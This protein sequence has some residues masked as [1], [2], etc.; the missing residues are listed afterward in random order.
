MNSRNKWDGQSRGWRRESGGLSRSKQIAA[1]AAVDGEGS[2][3]S[4]LDDWGY[5]FCGVL[6]ESL[7]QCTVRVSYS[8]ALI[9]LSMF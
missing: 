5:Q 2:Y 1:T 7:A 6:E 8:E 9:S 3:L 4:S